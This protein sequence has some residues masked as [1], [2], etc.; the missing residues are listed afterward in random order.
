MAC[1]RKIGHRIAML[2]EGRLIWQ[3]PVADIDHCGNAYVDQ[4]IHGRAEGPDPDAG[5]E[6]LT[7]AVEPGLDEV[8]RCFAEELRVVSHL[9]DE[10]SSRPS[11]PC[12]ASASSAPDRGASST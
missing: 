12:R 8:R 11:P 2:Y 6:A 10:R 4:F 5:P 1:A 3:G 9:G 7:M